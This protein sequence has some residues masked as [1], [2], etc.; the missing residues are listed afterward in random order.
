MNQKDRI[1]IRFEDDLSNQEEINL[2]NLCEEIMRSLYKDVFKGD[3]MLL[4]DRIQSFFEDENF[5]SV[6]NDIAKADIYKEMAWRMNTLTWAAKQASKIDGDFVECGVFRGF[7]S[8]FILKYIDQ[9]VWN[10]KKFWLYDTFEGQPLDFDPD[11]PVHNAEHNKPQLYDFIKDR[12]KVFSNVEIVKG[13][14]PFSLED[15]RPKKISFLHLDMNSIKAEIG[16]LE[17]LFPRMP[18]GGLCILDDYGLKSFHALHKAHKRWF[19]E[20]GYDIL[21]MPTGQGVVVK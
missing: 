6:F 15:S 17:L 14:V 2:F 9:E 4:V 3:K 10:N 7:K 1:S 20:R 8:F 21:E 16:A 18:K 11:S 12:F 19:N 5:T 13:I